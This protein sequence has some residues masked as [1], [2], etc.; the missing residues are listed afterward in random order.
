MLLS[1]S[2]PMMGNRMLTN[3]VPVPEPPLNRGESSS[4]SCQL[5]V[6]LLP[7][8]PEPKNMSSSSASRRKT[9]SST[10][11]TNTQVRN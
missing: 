2:T 5:L 7:A 9:A 3:V 1:M 6:V 10:Y 4:S 11:V 8:S